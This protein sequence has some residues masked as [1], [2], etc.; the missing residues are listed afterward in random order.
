[1]NKLPTI[2]DDEEEPEIFKEEEPKIEEEPK[3]EE[4]PFIEIPVMEV[5]PKKKKKKKKIVE[6]IIEDNE[7]IEPQLHKEEHLTE[8]EK[9]R[10]LIKE[11][12]KNELNEVKQIKKPKVKRPLTDKQKAHL[13]NMRNRA[14]E[15]RDEKKRIKELEEK[16]KIKDDINKEK[17]DIYI[18]NKIDEERKK[19]IP[20]P[21]PKIKPQEKP[22]ETPP[23]VVKIA[24]TPVLPRK[25]FITS[26]LGR[27]K[28]NNQYDNLFRF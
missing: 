20:P 14:K 7:L 21:T 24:P 9:T 6:E 12:I 15:K 23:P 18:K 3:V 22:K 27:K 25:K 5:K 1:M 16:L 26:N 8:Q 17:V 13:E 4:N 28:R 2:S 19:V 11:T 10:N